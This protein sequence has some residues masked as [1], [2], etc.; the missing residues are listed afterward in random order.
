MEVILYKNRADNRQLNKSSK[1]SKIKSLN[2]H[3]KDDT[4]IIEPILVC[5]LLSHAKLR[6]ANYLYIPDFGRY[7]FINNIC[8]PIGTTGRKSV[9]MKKFFNE[10]ETLI[11]CGGIAYILLRIVE[12]L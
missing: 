10:L 7:Y 5:S 2:A 9:N 11:T 12:S 1:L 3:L 6:D 4:S 8:C